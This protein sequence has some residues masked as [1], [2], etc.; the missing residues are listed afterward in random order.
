MASPAWV[1]AADV[2]AETRMSKHQLRQ[3]VKQTLQLG[4]HYINGPTPKSPRR[5]NLEAIWPLLGG[6][7]PPPR[8]AL[9]G[10][11]I[12]AEADQIRLHNGTGQPPAVVQLGGLNGLLAL[13]DTLV[14]IQR[15]GR[16]AA[17][18]GRP[19]TE[20]HAACPG[21]QLSAGITTHGLV[22][23]SLGSQTVEMPLAE[24]LDLQG[25][26][27]RQSAIA[28]REAAEQ[29]AALDQL[30]AATPAAAE[31]SHAS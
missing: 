25:A 23:L 28:L 11:E 3:M 10:I 6:Q 12:D 21:L 19:L 9:Q 17:G 4:I 5:Y 13:I 1:T 30:L 27:S 14:E 26:L 2:C 18:Q 8:S 16:R 22:S 20:A 31:V 7:L 24:V 15:Q 29:R